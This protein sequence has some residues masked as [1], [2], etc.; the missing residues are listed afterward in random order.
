VKNSILSLKQKIKNHSKMKALLVLA[1]AVLGIFGMVDAQTSEKLILSVKLES[2]D[3]PIITGMV[4]NEKGEP[5]EGATIQIT[6]PLET[7]ETK[8][9]SNGVFSYQPSAIPSEN[10]INANI[11]AQKDGYVAGY[12]N[13]SFFIKSELEKP[14]LLGA[15]YKV[16]SGDELKNDPLALKI[17]QNIE[18]NK[19]AEEQRLKRLQEIEERQ[20][21]IEEQRQIANQN[22]LN[23]LSSFFEQFDPFKPR[24][25]FTEF[26]SQFDATI[27]TIYWAQFNFTEAKTKEGLM[28][29]QQMLDAGGTIQDARQAFYQN[30]SSTRAEII[31]LNNEINN[32]TRN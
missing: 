11:K 29:F 12:T 9:D 18:Q 30:A 3:I 26:V 1:F 28:A 31:N 16:I 6:T 4:K 7:A 5:I 23:D 13:A 27:Q 8:S 22:L 2:G 17:L 20:R 14:K 25:A 24:N 19:K 32:R 21:F 10:T 15:S